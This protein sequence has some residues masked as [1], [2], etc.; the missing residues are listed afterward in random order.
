ME[1]ESKA[2]KEA[3]TPPDGGWGWIVAIGASVVQMQVA[4]LAT[5]FGVCFAHLTT[6]PR[7]C[8]SR[9]CQPIYLLF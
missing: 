5:T 9:I 4:T 8:Q 1:N 3:P 2:E 7:F 6:G